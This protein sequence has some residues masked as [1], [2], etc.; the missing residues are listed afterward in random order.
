MG[1]YILLMW[2]NRSAEKNRDF[3]QGILNNFQFSSF[4]FNWNISYLKPLLINLHVQ[5]IL[6]F[7]ASHCVTSDLNLSKYVL[8]VFGTPKFLKCMIN[9]IRNALCCGKKAQYVI[10]IT[11]LSQ[12]M[13]E[14]ERAVCNSTL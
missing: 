4:H 14:K 1:D 10:K 6:N 11:T 3:W 5:N 12:E 7:L 8:Y 13:Q 9:N 2:I